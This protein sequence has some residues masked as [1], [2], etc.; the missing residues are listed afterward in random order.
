MRKYLKRAFRQ[1]DSNLSISTNTRMRL[2]LQYYT[3]FLIWYID[4]LH[5]NNIK[6]WAEF[7]QRHN[8]DMLVFLYYNRALQYFHNISLIWIEW[9]KPLKRIIETVFIIFIVNA[10]LYHVTVKATCIT[11]IVY[12]FF[13][14]WSLSIISYMIMESLNK[15]I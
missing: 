6:L 10:L 4:I 7:C 11:V 13:S 2:N 12:C 9:W 15:F 3:Y 8:D 14:H 1:F 5:L